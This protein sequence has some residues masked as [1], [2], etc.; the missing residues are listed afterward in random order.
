MWEKANGHRKILYHAASLVKGSTIIAQLFLVGAIKWVSPSWC[1]K[2]VFSCPILTSPDSRGNPR[3]I[4]NTKGRRRR[5]G[6]RP[7]PAALKSADALFVDFIDKCLTWVVILRR[8]SSCFC[9][10]SGWFSLSAWAKWRKNVISNFPL[11][12]LVAVQVKRM[13][14]KDTFTFPFPKVLL[15]YYDVDRLLEIKILSVIVKQC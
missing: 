4:T 14:L 8:R 13:K 2:S 10:C 6:S 1:T 12:P 15:C 5:P 11:S 3:T 7:L 9:R